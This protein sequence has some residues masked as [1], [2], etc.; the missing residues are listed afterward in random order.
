MRESQEIDHQLTGR[1][2]S[3][4]LKQPLESQPVGIAREEL[5]AVN[6][7]EQ[8]HGFA[9]QRVDDMAIIDDMTMFAGR[10]GAPAR[11]RHEGRAADEQIEA[12][13]VQPD[14]QPMSDELRWHRVYPDSTEIRRNPLPTGVEAILLAG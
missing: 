7:I 3:E 6:E 4:L 13:I 14:P 5:V 2:F 11:Q 8:R 12:V 10:G 1:F 9:A